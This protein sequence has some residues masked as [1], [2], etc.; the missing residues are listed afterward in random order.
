MNCIE[1][2]EIQIQPIKPHNGLV[3]FASCVVNNQ[4]YIGNIA[5]LTAPRS[6]S[7]YRLQYPNKKI[8][9]NKYVDCFHPLTREAEEA[10]S[11]AII[12]QY[13]SLMENFHNVE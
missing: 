2:T 3:G 1:P 11:Q 6:K 13:V 4:F 9:P 12:R 5:I 10:V 8:G 7:G